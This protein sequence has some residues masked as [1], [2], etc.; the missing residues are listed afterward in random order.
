M[1]GSWE[2]EMP[3]LVETSEAQ[4]HESSTTPAARSNE[5]ESRPDSETQAGAADDHKGPANHNC[6]STL[7]PSTSFTGNWECGSAAVSKQ[8]T[9]QLIE[10][11]CPQLLNAVNSCCVVHDLCYDE[12]LGQKECDV[13]FCDCLSRV[14]LDPISN[15]TAK[16]HDD[17]GPW[18]CEM[19]KTFGDSYYENAGLNTTLH[20]GLVDIFGEEAQAQILASNRI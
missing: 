8:I 7:A 17:H 2:D 5:A 15:S 9:K 10:R 4:G 11:D 19:V 16:C 1:G 12:Q 18:F 6:A 14:T 3:L 20:S 13:G